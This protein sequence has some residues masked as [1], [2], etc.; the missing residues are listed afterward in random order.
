MITNIKVKN[1]K[2]YGDPATSIDLELKTNKVNLLYAPNGSGKS[3]LAAAFASL[4]PKSLRVDKENMYHKDD[5]LESELS[6]TLDGTV[7]IANRQR[8][9]ISPQ[10][11]CH[12]IRAGVAPGS[13]QHNMGKGFTTVS[14]F[15]DIEDIELVSN[16]P[17]SIV[18]SYKILEI[19]K[20]FGTNGKVLPNFSFFQDKDFWID[21]EKTGDLINSFNSAKSRKGIIDAIVNRIN[22]LNGTADT[23][24]S[25]IR[26]EWFAELEAN[27]YYVRII[28]DLS[29]Y[30]GCTAFEHF[31]FFY[32]LVCF[33]NK[34]KSEIKKANIR[35]KYERYREEVDR[36]I[37][38]LDITWKQIHTTETDG[39]LMLKFPHADEI[40]NG[41]RDNLT[42]VAELF[43]FQNILKEGKQYMLLIDEVF[44]Y[45]DDANVI[46]AQCFLTN[47]LKLW[48]GKVYLCILTHLSPYSFKNYIFS[49]DKIN[50]VYLFNTK[51]VA[52][53]EMKAFISFR[54]RLDREKDNAQSEL[55]NKLSR[56][57]F[58][59][60]P[61]KVDYQ[62]D[63]TTYKNNHHLK[64][65]WGK[66]DVLHN[67]LMEEVNK[68]LSGAEE[69][70]PYAVSMALR[71]RIE[72]IMYDQ[73]P[74][75]ELKD[76]FVNEKM[77]KNKM[78]Y[79][80]DKG[81][82]MPEVFNIANAIHNDADHLKFDV[83]QDRY[84][85][86]PMVY[87]L[88]NHFIKVLISKLFG[89]KGN[90]LATDVID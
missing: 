45:L 33:W 73:L 24:I 20:K 75:Q 57:L 21:V 72:K 2:G 56:D 90:C 48:K 44:D 76:G 8:N 71:L 39:K 70:D 28:N 18:P 82:E 81:Y 16:V 47:M 37:S 9:E 31:V 34:E 66:T 35:T 80:A 5:A 79:C 74:T 83:E 30:A 55:Y 10:L 53:E 43:R 78:K 87:K 12:V 14:S 63:I 89:W 32:E 50:H 3:S 22:A 67:V 25:K 1:I 17:P 40:S 85:E 7:L 29:G 27:S 19:R 61:V 23:V 38:L 58:H 86:K 4:F 11:V 62:A 88:Q 46:V 36:N 15:L 52:M 65:S 59:Y 64:Q 68:Y 41:Q 51:P 54:E 26:D 6:I 60:N 42:F 84:I 77:T 49:D 13:I 69:Y